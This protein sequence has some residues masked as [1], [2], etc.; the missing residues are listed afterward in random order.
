MTATATPGARARLA[1]AALLLLALTPSPTAAAPGWLPPW[2]SQAPTVTATAV[3]RGGQAISTVCAGVGASESSVVDAQGSLL[4]ASCN[5]ADNLMVWLEPLLGGANGTLPAAPA[6]AAAA[7]A[8]SAAASLDL[9][10]PCGRAAAYPARANP[11]TCAG[12][13]ITLKLTGGRC[14]VAADPPHRVTC[15]GPS[16]VASPAPPACVASTGGTLVVDAFCGANLGAPAESGAEAVADALAAGEWPA[17]AAT[18]AGLASALAS[19]LEPARASA[20][21]S[22]FDLGL[23]A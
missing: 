16:L 20:A 15:V 17:A 9:G 7:G 23:A 18:A 8:S 10:R 3:G 22:V 4:R 6:G 19:A 21:A 2:V 13:S 1:L 11:P 5:I 12:P 14:E